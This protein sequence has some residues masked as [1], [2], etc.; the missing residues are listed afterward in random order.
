MLESGISGL[1]RPLLEGRE[2]TVKENGKEKKFKSM[3]QFYTIKSPSTFIFRLIFTC[4][5]QNLCMLDV[6][7]KHVATIFNLNQNKKNRIGNFV[8]QLYF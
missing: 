2:G 4:N 5:I 6:K 1:H 8:A 3:K 7:L